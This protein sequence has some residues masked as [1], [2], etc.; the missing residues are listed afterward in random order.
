MAASSPSA[1]S[2]SR[3]VTG[4][5][6]VDSAVVPLAL[7]GAAGVLSWRGAI[8]ARVARGQ[9]VAATPATLLGAANEPG[10]L[11]DLDVVRAFVGAVV[12]D[13][14][15]DLDGIVA[16]DAAGALVVGDDVT[17]PNGAILVMTT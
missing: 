5:V 12:G 8:D 4:A 10:S 17:A 6:V 14:C 13:G 3:L 9:Q 2:L 16:T 11:A 15:G 7:V 1:A